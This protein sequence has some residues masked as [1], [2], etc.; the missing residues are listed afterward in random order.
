MFE[1]SGH[2][3]VVD[4]ADRWSKIF[5]A[6]LASIERGARTGAAQSAE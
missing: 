5:F 4:A 1:G 2:G 3:P 6:F